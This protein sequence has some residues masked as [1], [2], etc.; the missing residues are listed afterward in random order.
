MANKE[1]LILVKVGGKVVENPEALHRLI[2]D[3][4]HLKGRKV[5]V[6][7]GGVLAT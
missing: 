5:L 6:H 3:L 1:K 7:G 4:S 2:T